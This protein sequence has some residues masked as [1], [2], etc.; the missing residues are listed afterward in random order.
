[1]EQSEE[2]SDEM[3]SSEEN[4]STVIE[5]SSSEGCMSF[6][7][8][9]DNEIVEQ[10]SINDEDDLLMDSGDL[11]HASSEK[12]TDKNEGNTVNTT[13]NEPDQGL[14][15]KEMEHEKIND[16]SEE[17]NVDSNEKTK[18]EESIVDETQTNN[19]KDSEDT[20]AE[21][22]DEW[23]YEWEE[24]DDNEYEYYEQDEEQYK[25]QTF[26]GSFSVAVNI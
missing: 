15:K 18:E 11:H 5:F 6:N 4:N 17:E 14:N 25:V 20:L 23:E 22:E 2:E 12:G 13:Q 19:I 8:E 9:I 26:D 21:S 3:T 1:M 7:K 24:E 10:P 16:D